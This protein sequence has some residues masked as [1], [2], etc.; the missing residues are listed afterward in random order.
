V[1]KFANVMTREG[2]AFG[3]AV[4]SLLFTIIAAQRAKM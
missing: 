1:A 3:Q 4:P 2:T